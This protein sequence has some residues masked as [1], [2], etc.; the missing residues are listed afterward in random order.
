MKKTIAMV[1]D[2]FCIDEIGMNKSVGGGDVCAQ[3]LLCEDVV[4]IE[5][6][7]NAISLEN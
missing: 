1:N 5:V 6:D 2:N 7:G 3:E 4:N